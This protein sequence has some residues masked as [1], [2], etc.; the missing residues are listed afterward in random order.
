[1]KNKQSEEIEHA[2]FWHI[3]FWHIFFLHIF[4]FGICLNMLAHDHSPELNTFRLLVVEKYQFWEI[5]F[6]QHC[7][8]ISILVT[9]IM[10]RDCLTQIPWTNKGLLILGTT[11]HVDSQKRWMKIGYGSFLYQL[12][13]KRDFYFIK[14]GWNWPKMTKTFFCRFCWTS[15]NR[16]KNVSAMLPKFNFSKLIFLDN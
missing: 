15:Q 5:E 8:N 16:Q 1:V 2:I 14:C 6:W 10:L 11:E 3:F 4:F 9:H 13:S 12:I 7:R